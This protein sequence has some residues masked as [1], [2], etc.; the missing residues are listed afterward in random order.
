MPRLGIEREE[1]VVIIVN[2]FHLASFSKDP[3]TTAERKEANGLECVKVI[4][5]IVEVEKLP[6]VEYHFVFETRV[7][8]VLKINIV[9]SDDNALLGMEGHLHAQR[10]E[11]K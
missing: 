4:D 1:S 11:S 3:N 2:E 9:S 7:S 5:E 6:S 8:A 10:Q